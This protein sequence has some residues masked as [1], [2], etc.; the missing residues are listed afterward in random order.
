MKNRLAAL[1]QRH[2]GLVDKLAELDKKYYA[3]GREP[4]D[5]EL[6]HLKELRAKQSATFDEM[7]EEEAR[8][9]SERASIGTMTIPNADGTFSRAIEPTRGTGRRTF[10][11]LFGRPEASGFKSFGEF[12]Q[13]LHNGLNDSRFQAATM[14]EG[15]G[16]DGGFLVPE[17]QVAR[18]LDA[19]LENEIVRPRARIEPMT[20]N[21]RTVAGFDRS[22]NTSAIGGFAGQ[23]LAE[24]GTMTAQKGLLR[25]ISLRA[26]KL[27]ILAEASNELVSDGQNF[28][29][30]LFEQLT[31]ALGW[32]MDSAFLTGDGV[33][34]PLGV[35]ND[36]AIV[37][38]PKEA[39]QAAATIR[40]E[41]VSKMFARLHPASVKNAVWVANPST[42]PQLLG[43]AST[44]YDLAGTT[45]T[46][47]AP[48]QVLS[49][50]SDGI[51][52]LTRPVLLTEKVPTLG[53]TGDL[54]LVDFSQYVIGLRREIT[55]D[56][57]GHAGFATDTTNYRGIVRVDGQGA[58]SKP[59][60]PK[61]GS[62]LSWCVKLDTRS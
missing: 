56:K 2:F 9:E 51:K 11:E 16:A 43:L 23:W 38:V 50:D 41:N 59:F 22:T 27:A 15:I 25:S 35:L 49:E 17:E 7:S 12:A 52:I 34:G 1:Q 24:G 54:M 13:I 30:L 14:K 37:S 6:A 33:S 47:V 18:M 60:T 28:E 42:L 61:N 29:T 45:V 62:T 46:G 20:S 55:L 10:A 3:G 53:T 5:A 21:A 36:P 39:T 48:V 4:T 44:F 32:F 26:K 31:G 40:F 8:V 57:S 58:W 19:S